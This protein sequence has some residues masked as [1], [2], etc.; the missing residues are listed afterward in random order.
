MF[1]HSR[2]DSIAVFESDLEFD[3]LFVCLQDSWVIGHSSNGRELFMHHEHKVPH[4]PFTS[5]LFSLFPA[6]TQLQSTVFSTSLS[7]PTSHPRQ[8]SSLTDVDDEFKTLMM[9][10]VKIVFVPMC[11]SC[12][13]ALAPVHLKL[14]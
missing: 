7:P 11:L 14:F 6:S 5:T 13:F 2:D 8:T 10:Q 12:A 3:W 9:G 4:E 1:V